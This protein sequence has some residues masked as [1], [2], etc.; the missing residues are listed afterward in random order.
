MTGAVT[1]FGRFAVSEMPSHK[2]LRDLAALNEGLCGPLSSEKASFRLTS[3]ADRVFA[4]SIGD[5]A[6]RLDQGELLR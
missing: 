1:S 3:L 2:L 6:V 4:A 5:E